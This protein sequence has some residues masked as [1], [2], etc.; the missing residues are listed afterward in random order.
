MFEPYELNDPPAFNLNLIYDRLTVSDRYH[1]GVPEQFQ[2]ETDLQSYMNGIL[3]VIYTLDYAEADVMFTKSAQEKRKWFHKLEQI[4]DPD[5]RYNQGEDGSRHN[6]DS[7]TELT[8]EEAEKLNTIDDLI[9][10]SIIVSRYEVNG[11]KTTGTLARNG[12]YVV[13]LFS[14]NYAG[15]QNDYGVSG[16]VMIRRQAFELL[17][18][19][20]YYDGMV[21][22]ISN[23]YKESAKSEQ[24]ILSDQYILKKI[25]GSTYET[26]AD[27]KIAMFQR[28]IEKINKLKPVTIMWKDQSVTINDFEELRLLMKEAIENDLIK[29]NVLPDGSNNIR[30]QATEVEHL[31]QEIFKAYLIKTEDFRESIYGAGTAPEKPG[32]TDTEQPEK[33]GDTDTEQ[34]EKPGDTDTKQP[35]KPGDTNTEQPEKPSDTDTKL[36]EKTDTENGNPGDVAVTPGNDKQDPTPKLLLC[37]VSSANT[38]HTLRWNPVKS[39][40]GY[41]IYGA[42]SNEKYK[43]LQTVGNKS[44]RWKHKKLKNGTQYKYYVKAYKKVGGKRVILAQSLLV[45]STTTG[46]KYGNPSKIAVKKTHVSVKSG[47]KI[48]LRV[49]VTGKKV[50]KTGKKVRYVSSNPSVATVSKK[51]VVIGKKRGSCTIYCIAQNGL[52]KEVKVKVNR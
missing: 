17:A 32:D 47:K 27:F 45:Y 9:R 51:G 28:R 23:Q 8:L 42:K 7:V 26:M 1:N 37:K 31:K 6:L 2:D 19:Y 38:S 21:P 40:D 12:Y 20:G 29:V 4:V 36:P 25:F 50:S 43:R 3:D 49:N 13:P 14:A 10:N 22:Y 46:G 52:Y 41:E 35:E 15:V 33:P 34:P 16:D 5:E 44:V 11:T 30:A 39:A 18:E 48:R 24:T